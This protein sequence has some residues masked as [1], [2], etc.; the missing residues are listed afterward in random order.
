MIE[1]ATFIIGAMLIACLLW[2]IPI[3]LFGVVEDIRAWAKS[4]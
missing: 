2:V 3:V 4:R 1:H